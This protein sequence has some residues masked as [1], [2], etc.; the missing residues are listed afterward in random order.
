MLVLDIWSYGIGGGRIIFLSPQGCPVEVGAERKA[1]LG[2]MGRY[3]LQTL[4][5]SEGS[6]SVGWNHGGRVPWRSPLHESGSTHTED[7]T[8]GRQERNGIQEGQAVA[9]AV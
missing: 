5:L 7:R 3:S 2:S 8:P 6:V 4:V 1:L 9:G